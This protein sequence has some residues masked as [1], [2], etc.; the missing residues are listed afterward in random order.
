MGS[1]REQD[2][3]EEEEE[4]CCAVQGPPVVATLGRSE[5]TE[6]ESGEQSTLQETG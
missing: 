3:K 5:K 1:H 2:P 6:A 4:K